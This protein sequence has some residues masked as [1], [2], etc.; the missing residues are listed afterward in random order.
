MQFFTAIVLP[1][2]HPCCPCCVQFFTAIVLP[3]FSNFVGVIPGAEPLLAQVRK[4]HAMWVTE[5]DQ[6]AATQ[7]NL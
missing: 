5:A 1:L 6:A 4:N 2:T 7:E 3:L